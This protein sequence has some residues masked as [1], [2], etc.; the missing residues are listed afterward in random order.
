M[1]SFSTQVLCQAMVPGSWWE[2]NC[3]WW[4]S[5]KLILG[6]IQVKIGAGEHAGTDQYTCGIWRYNYLSKHQW[7]K[8]RARIHQRRV[9]G[10]LGQAQSTQME[11]STSW[12]YIVANG[13]MAYFWDSTAKAGWAN[14]IYSEHWWTQLSCQYTRGKDRIVR[15]PVTGRSFPRRIW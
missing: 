2:T 15:L 12:S 8:K 7:D 14:K 4:S 11:Y 13:Y 9:Q 1:S 5:P 6:T 3:D 10:T